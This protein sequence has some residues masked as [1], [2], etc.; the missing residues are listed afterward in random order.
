MARARLIVAGSE[1]IGSRKSGFQPEIEFEH[2]AEYL[3]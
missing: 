1:R 2:A 3:K